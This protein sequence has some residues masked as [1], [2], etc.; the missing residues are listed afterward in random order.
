MAIIL[1][2]LFGLIMLTETCIY[3]L[4]AYIQSRRSTR[5][6]SVAIIRSPIN[7]SAER[8]GPDHQL[9][10]DE[11]H[12]EAVAALGQSPQSGKHR[13]SD[14]I[15][16]GGAT[17]GDNELR[18]MGKSDALARPE[19]DSISLDLPVPSTG[20]VST[21]RALRHSMVKPLIF[22]R[23]RIVIASFR[24][25]LGG[26]HADRAHG[27]RA[28]PTGTTNNMAHLVLHSVSAIAKR[29]KRGNTKVMNTVDSGTN[30][31]S[32]TPLLSEEDD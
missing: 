9:D 30:P 4:Y 6:I 14:V 32:M 16:V 25:F 29:A 19:S 5:I 3:P 15:A 26:S 28:A 7:G 1:V 21:T 23:N 27:Q 8:E 11:I 24:G 20:E 22:I 2:L 18:M 17:E 10:R 13:D 12:R 31:E